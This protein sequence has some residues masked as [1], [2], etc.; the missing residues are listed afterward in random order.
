MTPIVG[1]SIRRVPFSRRP[2]RWHGEPRPEE[3][4]SLFCPQS[5]IAIVLR[6]RRRMSGIISLVFCPIRHSANSFAIK[7]VARV[8]ISL[9]RGFFVQRALPLPKWDNGDIP[10]FDVGSPTVAFNL[11]HDPI[12]LSSSRASLSSSYSL[13]A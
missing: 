8:S 6:N 4:G 2:A 1:P 11:Q 9:F 12:E 13:F 10:R 7:Y 3:T 5:T